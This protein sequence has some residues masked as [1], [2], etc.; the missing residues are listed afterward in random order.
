MKSRVKKSEASWKIMKNI[1]FSKNP[2]MW[3]DKSIWSICMPNTDIWGRFG[4]YEK[5]YWNKDFSNLGF[6]HFSVAFPITYQ[7]L[8]IENPP[9]P[10]V[11]PIC[12]K[13]PRDGSPRPLG[14]FRWPGTRRKAH[15]LYYPKK[16][17]SKKNC[18]GNFS[19]SKIGFCRKSQNPIRSTP[20]I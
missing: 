2:Q 16:Y 14:R 3:Q 10:W 13:L 8:P 9:N 4:L 5:N 15:E 11:F 18:D 6:G 7:D 20:P 17:F 19:K 12:F 1:K